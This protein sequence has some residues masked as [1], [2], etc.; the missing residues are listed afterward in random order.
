M[1]MKQEELNNR[2]EITENDLPYI[3][4]FR[5]WA[6]MIAATFRLAMQKTVKS[7]QKQHIEMVLTSTAN[8]RPI[9]VRAEL[10]PD[11]N[12]LVGVTFT[13]LTMEKKDA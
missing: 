3:K 6:S 8:K 5:K 13:N 1:N 4:G 9:V 7:Q 2:A 10:F 11:N 12:R